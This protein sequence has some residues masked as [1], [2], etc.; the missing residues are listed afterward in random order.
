MTTFD[1]LAYLTILISFCRYL[2]LAVKS[3]RG[4]EIPTNIIVVSTG[5]AK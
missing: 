1:M 2:Y 3:E 5:T 4:M